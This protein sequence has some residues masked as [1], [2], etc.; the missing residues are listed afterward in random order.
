MRFWRKDT[1]SC[2]RGF[3]D[4]AGAVRLHNL[5][6]MNELCYSV[7]VQPEKASA[8]ERENVTP[9]KSG[10]HSFENVLHFTDIYP[11]N[12][13]PLSKGTRIDSFRILTYLGR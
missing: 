4:K 13:S 8:R 5:H 3:D 12:E 10:H 2:V 9:W 7:S 1:G 6:T 11:S